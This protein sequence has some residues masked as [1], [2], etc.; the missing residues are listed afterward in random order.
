MLKI[1]CISFFILLFSTSILAQN[2]YY[3]S[4]FDGNDSYPGTIE[5]PWQTIKKVN[6]INFQAGDIIKFECGNTWTGEQLIIS[7]SGDPGRSINYES[8]IGKHGTAKPI[9]TM[10]Y[11]IPETPK[12]GNWTQVSNHTWKCTVSGAEGGG[13]NALLRL[14]TADGN[15]WGAKAYTTT[16]GATDN[17]YVV[18]LN[19]TC[20]WC[21]NGNDLYIYSDT[22]PA[23][24]FY[25]SCNNSVYQTSQYTLY[26]TNNESY[27]TFDGLD[28][29]YGYNTVRASNVNNITF[30]NCNIGWGTDRFAI[31][32]PNS[33]YW[34]LDGDTLDSG[35][36]YS[37]TFPNG[38]TPFGYFDLSG[39]DAFTISG[40]YNKIH[41]C[42]FADWYHACI[43]L[44]ATAEN[45]YTNYNEIYDNYFYGGD[46][47]YCRAFGIYEQNNL[48]G[49]CSYNRVYRNV[50]KN[51]SAQS[52]L[53]GDHNYVYYNIIDSAYV[54]PYNNDNESHGIT[55]LPI[56]INGTCKYNYVFNNT[57]NYI[58]ERPFITYSD[59]NYWF[60]NLMINT[61]A[62]NPFNSNST[63]L[64]VFYAYGSN[65]TIQNNLVFSD[66][67]GTSDDMFV[68][69]NVGYTKSEFNAQNGNNGC[70]ISGNMQATGSKFDLI[71][72]DWTLPV[73]SPALN[74]GTDISSIVPEGFTDMYSNTVNISNPNIGAIDNKPQ[75]KEPTGFK[76]YLE[77]PYKNGQMS[78]M[79][80]DNGYIPKTQPYNINL[81]NYS[82]KNS[83]SIIPKEIVDWVI[84]ELRTSPDSSSVITRYPA[85]LRNDGNITALDG[86]SPLTFSNNLTSSYY[87]VIRHR[88]HLAIMSSHPVQLTNSAIQYDFTTSENKAYGQN[89]MV[90]LGNGVYGMYG[91]DTN[92]D[93]IIDE[94]DVVDVSQ[95]LFYSG[96]WREDSNLNSPVNVLDYKLPNLNL[97]KISN[98]Q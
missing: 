38:L 77:G 87:V 51:M 78:Y 83:V 61:N 71:N 16:E 62:P 43:A 18:G 1:K 67:M 27:I 74:A 24:Q 45:D 39:S 13:N 56:G 53:A 58:E 17:G 3:V 35:C 2:I 47:Q 28:F 90:D 94:K 50:I 82:G 41:N 44:G 19:P 42:Y 29:R 70:T 93:G 57:F 97:G 91:G 22:N 7:R 33:N 63:G 46:I 25:F 54:W 32:A 66:G 92:G 89:S 4:Y 5:K 72:S 65:H 49:H 98:I 73:G 88:N 48:V 14:F 59:H 9:I 31:Y 96:Y 76:V 15:D 84:I 36:R 60:N 20:N 6:T 8:Y 12:S 10:R 81:L 23:Q 79:L 75:V 30:K 80:N 95:K 86:V 55:I 64:N 40:S 69:Q 68:L 37:F 85:F 26:L 52:Q 11:A 34:I 21:L